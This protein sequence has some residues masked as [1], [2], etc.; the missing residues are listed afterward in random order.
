M[1]D[2]R[3]A[4]LPQT[5]LPIES[6]LPELGA[7]L[8]ARS[9]A[10]LVAPPGAGKTTRV[11]LALLN[12]PWL[13]GRRIILLEPRRLAAR[14]AASRMSATLGERVGDTIGL[15]VRLETRVS[16][17]TRIEVV[18]EGV[19][20]RMIVADPA[21]EGVG[22]VLFDEFHERSLDADVGLA[23]A[24][25]AQA[26][27]RDDLR[28]LVMSATLDGA[29]VASLLGEAP[30]VRSEGR[31]FPVETRYLGRDPTRRIEDE[32]VEAVERAL[33]KQ[34]GSCLVFLPGA[35]EIR[36][37]AAGLSSRLD[38]PTTDVVALYGALDRAEQDRAIRPAASGR[39]KV[40]L[41]TA[42]AETSLTIEGVRLVV[43]SG[44]ARVPRYEPGPGLTRL[45]TIRVSRAS[46]DQR[47]GRAGRTEPGI[48][49]RLWHEAATGSLEPFTRPE[50]LSADL[51][52]LLLDCAEWGVVDPT[53][54]PFLDRPPT[55]AL[56]EA[57]AL[58][59]DLGALDED[60]R[61]TQTGRRLRD[62]PLPPRLAGMVTEAARQGRARD[63][64]DLAAI[65]AE[66]GFGGDAADLDER[67]DR[68][69]RDPSGRAKETRR[70]AAGW[71]RL[72]SGSGPNPP[73]P[74]AGGS[75]GRLVALA[76]PDRIAR[77]RGA[78]GEYV[79]ANGRGARLEA[80]DPLARH[81]FLAVAEMAGSAARVSY[82][83]R[84]RDHPRRHRGGGGR[85]DRIARGGGLRAERPRAAGP[86]EPAPRRRHP[87]RPS[88]PGSAGRRER[89][90]PGARHRGSRPRRTAVVRRHPAMA[91]TGVMFLRESRGDEWPDL[92]DVALIRTVDTWLV[93]HLVGRTGLADPEA[94]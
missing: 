23:L 68:F 50:I 17:R 84:G 32:V 83:G 2:A 58:L 1:V 56:G 90:D 63:A 76:Y 51:A 21:L 73:D 39:R 75:I 47:R 49:Y 6:V 52:P 89:R 64:A 31:A 18:T 93:P 57:R 91:G 70:L 72:A 19:F 27:L 28:L 38:D 45:E 33:R 24:I 11:P 79:L 62:L 82:P 16:D 74:P 30:V 71:A 65:L 20:T 25:E 7:A 10:V 87:G 78:P 35:G 67:L 14:A 48:C 81:P 3:A 77:T 8:S 34:A 69:R 66:R 80:H 15:R 86:R 53:T 55:A 94:R 61:I 85:P 88:R 29:R 41:A 46:A 22:A 12:A 36:R 60:G 9:S 4:A 43:D 42:I 44:L 54:L 92:S 37:V 13:C 59:R 40:V 26:G 5:G